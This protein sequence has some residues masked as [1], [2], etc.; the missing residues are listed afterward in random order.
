MHMTRVC[1]A[2]GGHCGHC[3]GRGHLDHHDHELSLYDLQAMFELYAP[4]HIYARRRYANIAWGYYWLSCPRAVRIFKTLTG[5]SSYDDVL[6]LDVHE[7]ADAAAKANAQAAEELKLE[8]LAVP[9]PL[10]PRCSE[11]RGIGKKAREVRQETSSRKR[12]RYEEEAQ[13]FKTEPRIFGRAFVPVVPEDGQTLPAFFGE[14]PKD[15]IKDALMAAGYQRELWR[16]DF[17]KEATPTKDI[18]DR[19]HEE[20]RVIFG[21]EEGSEDLEAIEPLRLPEF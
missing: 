11:V 8:G 9:K 4:V 1:P 17:K 21:D 19:I 12:K 16:V 5:A 10:Q 15:P 18:I 7:A 13:K 3:G 6:G 20:M 2:L 14:A